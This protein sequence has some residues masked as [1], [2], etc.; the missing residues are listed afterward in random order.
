MIKFFMAPMAGYTDRA[1]RQLI[2]ENGLDHAVTEM[3]SAKAL[4]F[5]DR[6]TLELLKKFPGEKN[7]GVQIF[8]SDVESIS[9][10]SYLLNDFDFSY[11]DINMGC[12]APKIVKNGCGSALIKNPNLVYELVKGAVKNSNKKISIKTRKSFDNTL[13]L[14]IIRAAQD[15]GAF[16]V[17]VHPRSREEYYKNKS[18]WQYL[19]KIKKFLTIPL[20][21]NGDILTVEDALYKIKKYNVDGIAIGRGAIENPLIFSQIKKALNG[22]K[23]EELNFYQ[24]IDIL[25]RHLYLEVNYKGQ[26]QAILNM[27]KTYAYYLKNLKNSKEIRNKLNVENDYTKV[28]KILEEYREQMR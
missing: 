28:V 23:Y 15:A 4:C 10:A 9:K 27:R 18:D 7:T 16:A 22:E 3:V 11:I 12:P 17:T 25:L 5:N 6:K 8:A 20:I 26:R 21:G 19:I 13:S 14:D 1:F 2:Y 24:R